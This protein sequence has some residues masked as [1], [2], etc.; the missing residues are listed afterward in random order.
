MIPP[1]RQSGLE[2]GTI[3]AD[4]PTTD[5]RGYPRPSTVAATITLGA[6]QVQNLIVTTSTDQTDASTPIAIAAPVIPA[7]C[8]TP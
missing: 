7:R 3:P 1:A 6:V 8:A 5:Q 2:R 4:E